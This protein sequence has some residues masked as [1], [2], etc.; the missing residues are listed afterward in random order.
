MQPFYKILESRAKNQEPRTKNQE[1]RVKNQESRVRNQEPK[2][3]SHADSYRD[4]SQE[5][6]VAPCCRANSSC[7]KPIF[8]TLLPRNTIPVMYV[9]D[10]LRGSGVA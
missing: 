7:G 2:T 1:P 4:K 8:F 3:K 6:M 10:R 5:P 9:R